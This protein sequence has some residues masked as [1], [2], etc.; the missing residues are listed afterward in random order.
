MPVGAVSNGAGAYC[1]FTAEDCALAPN[2]CSPANP[3]VVDYVACATGPAGGVAP[4]AS[5]FC[6]FDRPNGA[7]PTAIGNLCYDTFF[8]CVSGPNACN[9]SVP[10]ELTPKLCFSGADSNAGVFGAYSCLATFPHGERGTTTGLACFT[11]QDACESAPNMCS[12]DAAAGA[13]CTSKAFLCASGPAASTGATWVCEQELPRG[14]SPNSAALLCFDTFDN[15]HA[16]PTSCSAGKPCSFESSLCATGLAGLTSNAYFCSS[17]IPAGANMYDAGVLCYQDVS[18]C[19]LG[20]NLCGSGNVSCVLPVAGAC[21]A[22]YYMCPLDIPTQA[23]L[24][25][26]GLCYSSMSACSNYTACG[27]L[28]QACTL[29]STCPIASPFTCKLA[30]IAKALPSSV[31]F[32]LSLANGMSASQ[33]ETSKQ[34]LANYLN[35]SVSSLSFNIT[36]SSGRKLLATLIY[37]TVTFPSADTATALVS[38]LTTLPPLPTSIF[39]S[40]VSIHAPTLVTPP[41]RIDIT[42]AADLTM[43]LSLSQSVIPI[44][45]HMHLN[46]TTFAVQPGGNVTIAGNATMCASQGDPSGTGLCTLDARWL[47]QHFSVGAQASLMLL[48]LAL[49]NGAALPVVGG[50]ASTLNGGS[51]SAGGDS[52]LTLVNCTFANNIALLGSG[53]AVFSSGIVSYSNDTVFSNNSAFAGFNVFICSPDDPSFDNTTGVCNSCPKGQIWTG[54]SCKPCA[55]GLYAASSTICATCPVGTTT[56]GP[57]APSVAFCNCA[58]GSYR[59]PLSDVLD[60]SSISCMPCP[61]GARCPGEGD[62]RAYAREGFWRES[63]VD[64]VNF[65]ECK[66]GI[67]LEEEGLPL[68]SYTVRQQMGGDPLL[69]KTSGDAGSTLC[70]LL[71]D[72]SLCIPPELESKCR[73]GHTGLLCSLCLPGYAVQSGFCEPCERR[74]AISKWTVGVQTASAAV[75]GALIILGICAIVWFPL[76]PKVYAERVLES[77]RSL[78]Q[79]PMRVSSTLYSGLRATLRPVTTCIVRP[80]VDTRPRRPH[81]LFRKLERIVAAMKRRLST[82]FVS[83][84]LVIKTMQLVGSFEESMAIPWPASF[85]LF[86]P[87]TSAS[88][89][90]IFQIP[91]LACLAPNLKLYK[92]TESLTLWLIAAVALLVFICYAGLRYALRRGTYTRTQLVKYTRQNLLLMLALL[93]ITY[94][95]LSESILS[96]FLCQEINGVQYLK[97]DLSQRCDTTEHD[98]WVAVGVFWFFLIPFGVP[99]LYFNIMVFYRVP[100]LAQLKFDIEYLRRLIDILARERDMSFVVH[101]HLTL[102]LDPALT[103]L[104][105]NRFMRDSK[106][107]PLEVRTIDAGRFEIVHLSEE[108]LAAI[109]DAEVAVISDRRRRVVRQLTLRARHTVRPLLA[110]IS[111]FLKRWLVRYRN[112]VYGFVPPKTENE[113][114]IAALVQHAK[115]EGYAIEPRDWEEKFESARERNMEKVARKSCGFLFHEFQAHAWYWEL[116]EMSKDLAISSGLR[117]IRPGSSI[118][119]FIGGLV[120]FLY[121]SAYMRVNPMVG[122]IMR[123]IAYMSYISLA[124]FFLL[125]SI[126][127]THASFTLNPDNDARIKSALSLVLMLSI[128]VVPVSLSCYAYY[129]DVV[130]DLQGRAKTKAKDES[131][132]E[133]E[134]EDLD[135]STRPDEQHEQRWL[136]QKEPFARTWAD[137]F[138]TEQLLAEYEGR[139]LAELPA[140]SRALDAKFVE[141]E[142][143]AADVDGTVSTD[144]SVHH[145]PTK[146]RPVRRQSH[147]QLFLDSALRSWRSNECQVANASAA[148]AADIDVLDT[149]ES[150]RTGKL[151]NSG[152]QS[153]ADDCSTGDGSGRSID[154]STE[155]LDTGESNASEPSVDEPL[156][157]LQHDPEYELGHLTPRA[158]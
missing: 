14:A 90:Q 98:L 155:R 46:G 140:P 67:C 25:P 138:A 28:S 137:L 128:F 88:N 136:K 10:C 62:N 100:Y 43:A 112:E 129:H 156:E 84:T 39:N 107:E 3:C 157:A 135:E 17:S 37:A 117:F 1:Y 93:K 148:A 45:V 40:T 95:P 44:G 70:A 54:V 125:G 105:W 51:I 109:E 13:R 80:Q 144:V 126:L 63:L 55:T 146:E 66:E 31:T 141:H 127:I 89:I 72:P 116:V 23:T 153:S 16:A 53:A 36:T 147:L 108:E 33:L 99:F 120:V 103:D 114:K 50:S 6:P 123:F 85:R 78:R 101:S 73:E 56:T 96:L 32:T 59:V 4:T 151:K 48:N 97:A 119:V 15:C 74:A 57:G 111:A 158:N 149:P 92:R 134:S 142:A 79:I 91:A 64:A 12:S 133:S 7:I 106:G 69:V 122:A 22:S 102:D 42:S 61:D 21:P 82:L 29:S 26:T 60:A 77:F 143:L 118:Q 145:I 52:V 124:G 19:H 154:V 152:S 113:F 150:V 38:T 81:R 24:A 27:S 30:T 41:T 130:A 47:S 132:T 65:Y 8:D 121:L 115:E 18:S 20:P 83:I 94:I 131:D 86:G 68:V 139:K 35:V 11:S 71:Q 2:F 75:G 5:F 9:T 110:A 49:I 76:L 87:A 58:S 104:L 34:L